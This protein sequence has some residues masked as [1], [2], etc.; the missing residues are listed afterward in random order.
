MIE[1]LSRGEY[2]RVGVWFQVVVGHSEHGNEQEH[3]KWSYF[4]PETQ[5]RAL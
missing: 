2:K 3:E 4:M 5:L 1:K